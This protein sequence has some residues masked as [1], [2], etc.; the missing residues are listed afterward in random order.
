[1]VSIEIAETIRTLP[2]KVIADHQGGMKGLSALP[3][4]ITDV[5]QQ[6]GF[7][8]LMA[9]AK[10]ERVFIKISGLYRSSKL[11]TGGYDDLEPLIKEF[12]R[13]V[14]GQ[15]IWASDWPHTGSGSSRSEETK[16]VPERFRS[17]DNDAVLKNVR[18]WVGREVWHMMTVS[19]PAR[20]YL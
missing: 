18:E 6:P 7:S 13:E 15:L 10:S 20:V 2:I 11:T 14:P 4:G 12:A 16:D 1:M 8:E 5:R 19:T 17:V 3:D 9:L